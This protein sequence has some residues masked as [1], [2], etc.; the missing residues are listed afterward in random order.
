MGTHANGRGQAELGAADGHVAVGTAEFADKPGDVAR[1]N[2]VESWIGIFDA[3]DAPAQLAVAAG[4]IA[5]P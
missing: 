5:Q 3:N 4:L 2:P 1:E